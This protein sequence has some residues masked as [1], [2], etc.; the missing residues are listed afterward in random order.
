M[1]M[2]RRD[3]LKSASL[4]GLATFLTSKGFALN[5][6]DPRALAECVLFPTDMA[7]PFP[8]D[9]SQDATKFRTIINEDRVGAPLH[10]TLQVVNV[11]DNCNPIPNA[12]V[13]LWHNDAMGDYS[14]FSTF[15]TEGE[16]WCRGIQMTDINGVVRFET[17]YP[18]WYPGR[19]THLHLEVY[20]GSTKKVTSQ[21]AFPDAVNLDVYDSN[22]TIY[23]KSRSSWLETNMQDSIFANPAGA[24]EMQTATM[25]KDN[26]GTYIGGIIIPI[27]APVASVPEPETG[28]EFKLE[29]N[30]P[31]PYR[32][33][34]SVA[35]T[36]RHGGD[37]SIEIFSTEGVKVASITRNNLG[38]GPHHIELDRSSRLGELASGNY[39]YQF[40]LENER[41]RFT[42][43]KVMTAVK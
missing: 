17:V 41:G 29:Q 39:V 34:T 20:L 8:M 16:T 12:R 21:I 10:L 5:G 25:V 36:L 30:Y 27:A 18:G 2:N 13:D 6:T 23:T 37:V 7:G 35:F 9:L 15:G 19:A 14:G 26:A 3:L 38:A 22:P 1:N 40:T 43:C 32:S 24:L 42:Q 33:A 28:G 11:N 4:A 31:N